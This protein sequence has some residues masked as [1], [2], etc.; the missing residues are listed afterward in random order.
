MNVRHSYFACQ[1]LCNSILCFSFF[2][3]L[4]WYHIQLFNRL[5]VDHRCNWYHWWIRAFQHIYCNVAPFLVSLIRRCAHCSIASLSVGFLACKSFFHCHIF[6]MIIPQ[7]RLLSKLQGCT[8]RPLED[9][10]TGRCAFS[11]FI[12]HSSVFLELNDSTDW[13]PYVAFWDLV[14]MWEK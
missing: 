6:S 1:S 9:L 4:Y 7:A 5:T 2:F 13:L 10:K 8:E 12:E 14:V 3:C 11:A